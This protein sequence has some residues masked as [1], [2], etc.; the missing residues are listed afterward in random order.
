MKTIKLILIAVA[1]TLTVSA[2]LFTTFAVLESS[3]L[4]ANRVPTTVADISL[5]AVALTGGVAAKLLIDQV[6]TDAFEKALLSITFRKLAVYILRTVAIASVVGCFAVLPFFNTLREIDDPIL[7]FAF[8][9]Q[10][11]FCFQ[12]VV[13]AKKPSLDL[14]QKG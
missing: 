8:C 4:G 13:Q 11:G 6:L 10:S 1:I 12:T 14:N 5:L 2:A 7:T 9:F 3:P